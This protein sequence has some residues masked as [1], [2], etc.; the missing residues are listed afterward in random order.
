M[1]FD[2]IIPTYKPGEEFKALLNGI[3]TQTLKPDKIIIINTE[4]KFWKKEFEEI[5]PVNVIHISKSEFD[6]GATRRLGAKISEADIFVCMTQDARPKDDMLFSSLISAFSDDKTAISYA[7]QEADDKAGEIERYTREFNYPGKDRVKTSE[8]IKNLGIKAWFCSDV[9]AAYRKSAYNMA[10]G[11]VKH[12]VFNED[13]LMA[14]KVMEM[15]FKVVYKADARVIHYHEYS[16]WQQ[17]S[18]NFDLGASH[19]EYREVFE[20][21]SSYKEGGR[22]VK[23][24]AKH[25]LKVGKFYLIPK[26]VLH[27]AAKLLGYKLGKKYDKLPKKLVLKF[28]MN[29]EYFK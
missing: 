9:C 1:T 20:K 4:E 8:D 16:L 10:G 3:L 7:R 11:F 13:M 6:H 28:C 26:L 24:T 17:F 22:L 19:R 15:G 27:S 2:I 12:T 18:R 29:K 25:L 5:I 14:A 21:V 23:D